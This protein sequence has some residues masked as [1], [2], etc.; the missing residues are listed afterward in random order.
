[1]A[2]AV[3]AML[4][5]N[6]IRGKVADIEDRYVLVI[7]K[8]E[9]DGV[10]LGMIFSVMDPDGVP[11]VDPDTGDQL[12]KRPIE[13]LRVKII[14]VYPRFSRAATYRMTAGLGMFT[15]T[16]SLAEVMEGIVPGRERIANQPSESESPSKRVVTVN[17]GDPVRQIG[18]PT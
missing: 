13:R 5:Q 14:D 2:E 9:D 11:V 18:E 3:T 7:N 8:G 10:E 16:A 1:M 17:I 12:G 6:Q 15:T 4:E